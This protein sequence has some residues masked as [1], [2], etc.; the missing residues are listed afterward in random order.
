MWTPTVT[1]GLLHL[2]GPGAHGAQ[3]TTVPANLLRLLL[4]RLGPGRF[5]PARGTSPHARRPRPSA[6][7]G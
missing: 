6:N 3:R 4:G 7:A 2:H 1:V 5:A